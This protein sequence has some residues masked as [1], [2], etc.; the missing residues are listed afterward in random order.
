M[1]QKYN[2]Y[3]K[4]FQFSDETGLYELDYENQSLNEDELLKLI[5]LMP[6][7]NFHI[8][9]AQL[10]FKE[11]LAKHTRPETQVVSLVTFHDFSKP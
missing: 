4:R 7:C 10:T 11:E 2:T 8:I 3:C 6:G 1:K 9:G 5:L